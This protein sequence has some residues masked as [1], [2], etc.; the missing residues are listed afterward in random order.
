MRKNCV[1]IIIDVISLC[2]WR[3]S[4]LHVD[5]QLKNWRNVKMCVE[6][7]LLYRMNTK[8][9]QLQLVMVNHTKSGIFL[10][11]F[12]RFLSCRIWPCWNRFSNKLFELNSIIRYL[13]TSESWVKVGL[14]GTLGRISKGTIMVSNIHNT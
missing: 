3:G 13:S 8:C 2:W 14:L 6:I 7:F 11:S 4:Y 5:T 10:A 1:Y 12:W 9:S